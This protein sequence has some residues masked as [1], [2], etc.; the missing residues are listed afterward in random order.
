MT[1]VSSHPMAELELDEL[2]LID[3]IVVRALPRC[4]HPGYI[5][6][7]AKVAGGLSKSQYVQTIKHIPHER[8]AVIDKS[9]QSLSTS[10]RPG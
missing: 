2:K 8:S 6:F 7:V 4:Y 5:V 3:S 9:D 10:F 1:F